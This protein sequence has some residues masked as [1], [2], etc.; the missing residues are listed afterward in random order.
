MRTLTFTLDTQTGDDG[1]APVTLTIVEGGDGTLLFTL[2]N[3][4]DTDGLI[5]DLRGLFFDV[6]DDSLLGNLTFT[7]SEITQVVQDGSVSNLGGGVSTNGVPDSPYEVGV[8]FGTPG[9]STDDYQSVSFVLSAGRPL[10]LD[11]IALEHFAVRQTSVSSADG[12]RE[13]SDKLYGD[14][15]YPVNALDDAAET[16][17][18][19]TVSGNLFANDIDLDAGDADGDGIPDGL[20]VTGIDGDAGSVGTPLELAPGIVLTVGADGSYGVD[21]TDADWMAEGETFT[22]DVTY[23]VDDGNGGFDS[24]TLTVTVTGV[25]DTP[26]ALDDSGSTDE[27]TAVGGNVLANDS[28][29]DLSDVLTVSAVNGDSAAVGQEVLLDSGALLTL[30]ADGTYSYDPNGAFD[31]LNDGETATDSF[32]YQ[33]SDGHGG[34]DTATVTLTIDGIGGDTGPEEGADHFGTFSNKKGTADHDISNVVL[35]LDDGSGDILKV[36]IDGWS[37][38]T[39]LDNV[40]LDSFMDNYGYDDY[41]LLAVSIKAG[42]N[43]NKDLGPGEGQFFL[44]DGDEDIDYV[45]G[46]DVPDGFT[47]A[48]LGAKAGETYQYSTDLFE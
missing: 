5:A 8:E 46:G 18:D 23:G 7:G 13:D 26:D 40:D 44:L 31:A 17:E 27:A 37:G 35:Y 25:N 3:D 4:Q 2:S 30:G 32:T 6:T 36:K 45:A 12:G 48:V 14:A 9:M 39:D 41:E 28:D 1:M 20:T 43:H 16:F 11:D 29:P 15:P 10:T 22:A 33:V 21:A 47:L 42:N 38:E 34:F 19:E 24:A